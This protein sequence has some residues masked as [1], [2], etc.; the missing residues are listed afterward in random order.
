M[1]HFPGRARTIFHEPRGLD[2][3]V[4]EGSAH[5][6]SGGQKQRLAVARALL[7][8]P[9]FFIFDEATSALDTLSE[10]LLQTSLEKILVGKTALFIAH[11][12][13]TIR[14]CDRVLVMQAGCIIQDGA[15]ADLAAQPGLFR[16]LLGGG[17]E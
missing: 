7:A 16:D 10:R 4:G 6:L 15:Y 12:L 1:P 8:A 11:R 3:E 9:A 17:N 14:G 5:A 13:S 2:T